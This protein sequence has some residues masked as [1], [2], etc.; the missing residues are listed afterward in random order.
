MVHCRTTEVAAEKAYWLKATSFSCA[1]FSNWKPPSSLP[2]LCDRVVKQL[3]PIEI[4][5]NIGL[6]FITSVRPVENAYSSVMISLISGMFEIVTS[7]SSVLFSPVKC[8]MPS[9]MQSLQSFSATS[10]NRDE[11]DGSTPA[12]FLILCHQNTKTK[13]SLN[14]HFNKQN[15]AVHPLPTPDALWQSLKNKLK[16][17]HTHSTHQSPFRSQL[18]Y[19]RPQ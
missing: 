5:S 8:N 16:R 9:S 18:A 3:K 2:Q 1:Q 6:L 12:M 4:L 13:N 15:Q 10:S 19:T 14:K 7:L 11:G 17:C